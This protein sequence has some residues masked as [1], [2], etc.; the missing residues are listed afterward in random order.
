MAQ[1]LTGVETVTSIE[2][3]VVEITGVK[4]ICTICM[5]EQTPY[6]TFTDLD[7]GHAHICRECAKRV[8]NQCE[9]LTNETA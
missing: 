9:K 2:K 7:F 3:A 5:T 8:K 6:M 4:Q 1:S